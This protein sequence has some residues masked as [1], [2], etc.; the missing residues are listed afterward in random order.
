MKTIVKAVAAMVLVFFLFTA[1][2]KNKEAKDSTVATQKVQ[3]DPVDN[4]KTG[5]VST[6]PQAPLVNMPKKPEVVET[7]SGA[8]L[9]QSL[10]SSAAI[11]NLKDSTHLFIRTADIKCR[12]NNVP[13]AT[14]QIEDI[15]RQLGGYVSYTTLT[16]TADNKTDIPVS[17]D[18][19]L[20]TTWYSVQN[21]M[22]IRVPNTN[23]D[24]ALKVMTPLVA[25]IDFRTVKAN[26]TALEMLSNRL[27]QIRLAQHNQRMKNAVDL[28]SKKLSETTTAE[29]DI[30]NQQ[31]QA[32]NSRLANLELTD[33]VKYSTINLS[34]YQPG[35]IEKTMVFNDKSVTP[36]EPSLAVQ[37]VSSA[38]FGWKLLVMLL[39]VFVK[40]WPLALIALIAVV[41][42][43]LRKL[44]TA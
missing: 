29:D 43:R 24:S 27:K 38:L 32:D 10:Q 1:C 9:P 40:L 30:L 25:H 12:V 2:N 4:D 20:Q 28:N 31:E 16:S 36:Y 8:T 11:E 42:I 17:P 15:A 34:L 37:L 5:M 22:T 44:K 39:L 6:P 13:S 41:G 14:Y 33:Q 35:L 18:S 19:S 7:T 26:N 21:N 23:L 3:T